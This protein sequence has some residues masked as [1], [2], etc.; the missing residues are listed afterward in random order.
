MIMLRIF[1]ESAVAS[2][3]LCAVASWGSRLWMQQ[4]PWTDLQDQRHCGDEAGLSKG[5]VWEADIALVKHNA[6][7]HLPPT[8]WR[9]GHSQG[10]KRKDKPFMSN[11]VKSNYIRLD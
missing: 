2:A 5:D 4:P 8:Q 7:Q 10:K 9:A 3:I 1:Y 6:G 11:H